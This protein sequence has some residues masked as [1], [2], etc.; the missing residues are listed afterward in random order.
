MEVATR[1][2][3]AVRMD[4]AV[5]SAVVQAAEAVAAIAVPLGII[6]VAAVHR[7]VF[8]FASRLTVGFKRTTF[9]GGNPE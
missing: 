5:P 6:A 7:D 3:V 1:A 8:A 4:R 2:A 9:P